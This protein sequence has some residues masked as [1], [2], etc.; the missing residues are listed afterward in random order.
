MKDVL[1]SLLS[2]VLLLL[3][4]CGGS[5][6]SSGDD[7]GTMPPRSVTLPSAGDNP[8]SEAFNLGNAM[9]APFRYV[10]GYT[11]TS[12]ALTETLSV[13][14]D[15]A[16]WYV[17]WD[18][19]DD[20][21]LH[22]QQWTAFGYE[23]AAAGSEYSGR[24]YLYQSNTP[25]L[26]LEIRYYPDERIGMT[27]YD[28]SGNAESE[29]LLVAEGGDAI[30]V[31]SRNTGENEASVVIIDSQ[32]SGVSYSGCTASLTVLATETGSCNSSVAF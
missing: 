14:D 9:S 3:S 20:D 10:D 5:S 30:R 18:G 12:G 22:Y 19:E 15:G 32:G 6:D 29:A 4:A 13:A 31:I 2:A 28:S 17:V 16:S 1:I 7:N 26:Q 21:G 27:S 23:Q 11:V 25:L 8:M 24:F